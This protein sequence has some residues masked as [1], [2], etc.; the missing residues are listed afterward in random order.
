MNVA[1]G[2]VPKD[3]GT[4]T[5]Y[6]N[7]RNP[8]SKYGVNLY[9]VSVGK[10]QA[11]LWNNDFV[12][13]NCF[14]IAPNTHN[15]KSQAKF[16]VDWCVKMQINMVIGVN[17]EAILCSIPHLP[18]HIRIL[19]RCAN[20][21]N[22]GYN[23]TLMGNDRLEA[24]F[25]ISPKLKHDLINKYGANPDLIHLIPNGI[26]SNP[27]K[28]A[29]KEERGKSDVLRLGFL[30]RLEHNQKGIM[31]I[32]KILN[33]LERSKVSFSLKIAGVGK[34]RK[35]LERSLRN[36]IDN[37]QVI[38]LGSIKPQEVP[39]FFKNIDIYI[40]PSHFEGCPNALIESMISGCVPFSWNI[41][42]ITDF[43]IKNNRTGFIH[44]L[45]DYKGMSKNIKFLD[46]NRSILNQFSKNSS[47]DAKKR[48][49]PD[50]TAREY[51]KV[52]KYVDAKE[53][54]KIKPLPWKKFKIDENF[55][56]KWDSII[57]RSLRYNIKL[58]YSYINKTI[59]H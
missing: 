5:F 1:Y 30:G 19:S 42:G 53:F 8:L 50:K 6:R 34:D 14:L 27:Y 29:Y 58:F 56:R 41:K 25:A 45:G 36:R 49:D 11:A 48:F 43:I 52:L 12:D 35:R 24:I 31:H 7:M 26:S 3:G 20:A 38:F 51:S 10:E 21:F 22:H 39:L 54:I 55:E 47:K 28:E 9:C 16:F 18:A 2:S 40:F 44:D 17:S 23:L 33:E 57:S 46:Q 59:N 37:G 13:D 4:F 15:V 32:P